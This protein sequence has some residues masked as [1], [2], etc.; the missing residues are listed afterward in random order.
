MT[1]TLMGR[2]QSRLIIVLLV[3]LPWTLL[4]GP[5][6]PA[7]EAALS[8][9]YSMIFRAVFIVAI[10]GAVLWE[11]VYHFIQQYRWE[12]DWPTGLGLITALPEGI[13]VYLLLGDNV[14][15]A[16]FLWHFITTWLLIWF[17]L[18]GPIRVLLPRWRFRGGR[19]V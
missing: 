17:V 14:P 2:V 5:F 12:K 11:P 3:G 13:V 6:L 10:I 16:A 7:G 18:N 15:T 1:P 4:L 19:I 8:D 9:V